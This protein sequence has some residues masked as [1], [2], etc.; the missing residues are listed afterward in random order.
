MII[1]PKLL[2]LLGVASLAAPL[3]PLYQLLHDGESGQH[4]YLEACAALSVNELR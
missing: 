3:C 4:H 2:G 1:L